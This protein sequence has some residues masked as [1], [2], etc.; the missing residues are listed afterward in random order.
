VL[1]HERG[2]LSPAERLWATPLYRM[3]YDPDGRPWRDR[4]RGRL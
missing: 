3:I 4:L 1:P 2:T